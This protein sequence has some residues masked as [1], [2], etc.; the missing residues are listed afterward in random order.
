[1]TF[2]PHITGVN[3][4]EWDRLVVAIKGLTLTALAGGIFVWYLRWLNHWSSRHADGEFQL[5]QTELDIDRASWVV[6]TALEWKN[7]QQSAIPDS[8]LSSIS[9]NLFQKPGE[10]DERDGPS[11]ADQLASALLGEASKVKLNIGGNEVE[12]TRQ[13]IKRASKLD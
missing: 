8:L 11:A 6:E 7:S 12:L 9:R 4:L 13:G 10:F 5:R 2:N 1:M 3:G